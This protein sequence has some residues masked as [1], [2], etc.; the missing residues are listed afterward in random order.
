VRKWLAIVLLAPA[1]AA[2]SGPKLAS[3][4]GRVVEAVTGAPVP[5]ASVLLEERDA[6]LQ[7]EAQSDSAGRFRFADL[8][9]GH[10][11]LSPSKTGFFAGREES[12]FTVRDGDEITGLQLKLERCG[13]ISGHILDPDGDPAPGYAVLLWPVD[14]R[15]WNNG[16]RPIDQATTDSRGQ[17]SF[18]GVTPGSYYISATSSGWEEPDHLTLVD[19]SGHITRVRELTTFYPSALSRRDAQ[20]VR[21]ATT[22]QVEGID[23][24]LQRGRLLTV[25]GKI[26]VPPASL[27]HYDLTVEREEVG[28]PLVADVSPDGSFRIDLPPGEHRLSLNVNDSNRIYEIASA[29][30]SLTDADVSNIDL[31]PGRLARV[32]I[33]VVLEGQDQPLT[34]GA[35]FLLAPDENSNDLSAFPPRDGTYVFEN[36]PPGRYRPHFNNAGGYLKSVRLNGQELTSP[37]IDVADGS[38][39]DILLTYSPKV[40]EINGDVEL[41]ADQPAVVPHVFVVAPDGD[42]NSEKTISPDIDQFHHFI[43]GKL[44]PGHYFAFAAEENDA[45]LWDNP[46]FLDA[47]RSDAVKLDL[48]ENGHE[49]IHLKPIAGDEI[50][51]I[52]RELGL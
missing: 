29:S 39:L 17:Y 9:P 5:K 52:R 10:Y 24:Q 7:L 27:G 3:I 32:R 16:H 1:L 31:H 38:N 28:I 37:I 48:K 19:A 12:F 2:Q 50:A 21:V 4:E 11:Y 20:P 15:R 6:G 35:A 41:S 42:W 22:Q 51:R 36:V 30:V 40:A 8:K 13:T 34:Q 25:T 26:D 44:R 45:A 23:L 14:R 43:C 18:S 33:R 49:S 46:A 47:L